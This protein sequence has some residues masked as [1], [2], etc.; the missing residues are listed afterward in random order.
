MSLMTTL[1]ILEIFFS[2][3]ILMTSVNDK[4]GLGSS[5]LDYVADMSAY[6]RYNDLIYLA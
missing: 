6:F 4:I 5:L 1:L 3:I 2:L